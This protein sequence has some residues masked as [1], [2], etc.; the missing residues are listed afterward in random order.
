MMNKFKENV[1]DLFENWNTIPNWMC[2]IRIALIP[3]FTVMFIKEQYIA[4]FV[5]MIVA[6]LTD[7]F[8]G[9][10]ARKYNLVSDIGKVFD[11]LADK[12]MHICVLLCLCIIGYIPWYVVAFIILKELV[13]S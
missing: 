6:A 10:I 7:V 4:A 1:K 2:F 11:P 5:T 9:K 3:V 12:L 8:D 13:Y